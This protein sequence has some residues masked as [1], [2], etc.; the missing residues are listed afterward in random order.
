[1]DLALVCEGVTRWWV[2]LGASH[3]QRNSPR[4]GERRSA[5]VRLL[6]C[7]SA[8]VE[9]PALLHC[10]SDAVRVEVRCRPGYDLSLRKS[11]SENDEA[12]SS[13]G[14]L[15][16]PGATPALTRARGQREPMLVVARGMSTSTRAGLMLP[17]SG[18][19]RIET[20][21]HDSL[22]ATLSRLLHL[23]V[24]DSGLL[25]RPS[26]SVRTKSRFAS[27]RRAGQ[28]FSRAFSHFIPSVCDLAL[29]ARG[30]SENL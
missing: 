11:G 26:S 30:S 25:S 20:T 24:E 3:A 19:R 23:V 12:R 22:G 6:G 28:H 1:M 2:F 4:L 17:P 29:R 14:H 5:F 21:Q 27:L 9:S 16:V 10:E 8:N 18:G 15:W 7:V 13:P